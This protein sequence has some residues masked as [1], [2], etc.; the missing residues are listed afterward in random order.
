[1]SKLEALKGMKSA[2][3]VSLKEMKKALDELQVK[4]NIIQYHLENVEKA[5][6]YEEVTA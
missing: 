2:Y 3:E 4:Y 5:I 6:E 1:M